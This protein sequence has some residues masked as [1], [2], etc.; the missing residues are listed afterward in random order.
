MVRQL[1]EVHPIGV[2]LDSLLANRRRGVEVGNLR[3][4]LNGRRD[5]AKALSD[6]AQEF[7]S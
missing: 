4:G 7:E 2:E 6:R 3:A 1:D 5:F